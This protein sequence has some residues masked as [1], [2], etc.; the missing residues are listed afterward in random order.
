MTS[1]VVS[2]TNKLAPTTRQQRTTSSYIGVGDEEQHQNQSRLSSHSTT[3]TSPH[4]YTP[5]SFTLGTSYKSRGLG[6]TGYS[7][8]YAD[9]GLRRVEPPSTGNLLSSHTSRYSSSS[10]TGTTSPGHGSGSGGSSN[11]SSV[12]NSTRSNVIEQDEQPSVEHLRLSGRKGTSE[13]VR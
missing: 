13:L 4:A 12:W 10:V 11:G 2:P 3:S 1:H 6:T 5:G 8:R 7:S 9:T